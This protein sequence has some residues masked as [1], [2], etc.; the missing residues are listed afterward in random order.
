M[1]VPKEGCL[2]CKHLCPSL[3][4]GQDFSCSTEP[5]CPAQNSLIEVKFVFP[6]EAVATE[7]AN[8]IRSGDFAT[9]SS[10]LG[11]A[12][13]RLKQTKTRDALGW[14]IFEK[15]ARSHQI[16]I[17]TLPVVEVAGVVDVASTAVASSSD[18]AHEDAEK[19]ASLTGL[20]KEFMQPQAS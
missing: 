20:G 8:A 1:I 5:N 11:K 17:S 10:S 14:A 12:A 19:S 13:K 2:Q 3:K 16:E 4:N 9:A 6:V 18:L 7:I 15:L